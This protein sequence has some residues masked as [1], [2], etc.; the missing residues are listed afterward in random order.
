MKRSATFSCTSRREPAQHTWPWLN[1]IASTTPSIAPSRSASSKT[2][3]GDL[4]P[5]SRDSFL[6]DPAVWRRRMRPTSV[7]PVKAI[8]STSGWVTII[9]P[10]LLLPVIT[11]ITPGGR[12]GL[13][14]DLGEEQGGQ[15]GVGS[16]L[17]HHRVAHGDRRGDLPGQHQQRE[18]PG[19]DLPNDA[20][21]L[22]IAQLALHQ[23]RPAGMIIEVARQQGHVDIARFADR[24]AVVHRFQH[25]QQAV[26]LLDVAG[27]GIQVARPH[28]AGGLAPGCEGPAGS[29][30]S[31]VHFFLPGLHGLGQR[32][33]GG[34]VIAGQVLCPLWG[35]PLVV[36]EQ[37][38]LALVIVQ[39][40][41]RR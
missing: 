39:P 13:G 11:L 5:S 17:E 20:H 35:D 38:K 2:T 29:G 31:L 3:N 26:V 34:G 19:D 9:V 16:R 32:L 14:D 7:E 1:Q 40:G 12:P 15:A 4:P 30:Y 37:P 18:I 27:D 10:A 22:V 24:F 23:L 28:V 41:E 6:P 36:D 8:L 33:A 21:R 25:G